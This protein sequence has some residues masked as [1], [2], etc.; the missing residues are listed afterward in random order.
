METNEHK[1]PNKVQGFG[2]K[3]YESANG[4]Y[5]LF[6]NGEQRGWV[7]KSGRMLCGV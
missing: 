5:D 1:D 7:R 6:A 2:K 4:G 3:V